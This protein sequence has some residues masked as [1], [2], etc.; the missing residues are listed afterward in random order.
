[1]KMKM[2]YSDFVC[3]YVS[4]MSIKTMTYLILKTHTVFYVF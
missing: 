2:I 1:M 4:C 3:P